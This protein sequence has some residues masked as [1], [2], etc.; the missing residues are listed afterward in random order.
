MGKLYGNDFSQTTISRFE[1]LN[2]SF[3]NMCKLKPLLEKWLNDA[4]EAPSRQTFPPP[5]W[6]WR[7][8]FC[9]TRGVEDPCRVEG[10][11][12]WEA[13]EGHYICI[14]V[15]SREDRAALRAWSRMGVGGVSGCLER[16]SSLDPGVTPFGT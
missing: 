7:E 16:I 4:G 13:V 12:D 8:T 14:V 9:W 5:Q 1:A 3:K 2:L 10:H 11:V 6:R 15:S